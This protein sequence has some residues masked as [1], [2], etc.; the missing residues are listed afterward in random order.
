[1]S[2][3]A[4]EALRWFALAYPSST[5]ATNTLKPLKQIHIPLGRQFYR[6]RLVEWT[7]SCSQDTRLQLATR[8]FQNTTG[9]KSFR[10]SKEVNK[11]NWCWSNNIF[12]SKLIIY[13][14]LYWHQ[15]LH[16]CTSIW[17]HVSKRWFVFFGSHAELKPFNQS[18]WETA[19]YKKE[20][21]YYTPFCNRL[22]WRWKQ[23]CIFQK[24]WGTD[25]NVKQK[26]HQKDWL[27]FPFWLVLTT[28]QIKVILR[29]NYTVRLFF[30]PLWSKIPSIQHSIKYNANFWQLLYT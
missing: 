24:N 4:K 29:Y 21:L 1:M 25:V 10:V 16:C 23:I 28:Q 17:V 5:S 6:C 22:S 18:F 7:R 11:T 27:V 15:T 26:L 30:Q 14:P 12:I 8:V 20:V 9:G 2:D 13:F 19:L 3:Y